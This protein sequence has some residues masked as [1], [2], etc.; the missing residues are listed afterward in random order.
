MSERTKA[1]VRAVA[2]DPDR[3]NRLLML[4]DVLIE[5]ARR[6]GPPNEQSAQ[7]VQTAIA[8]EVL[9]FVPVRLENLRSLRMG[10]HLLEGADKRLR[11][12]LAGSETKTGEPYHAILPEEVTRHLKVYQD[13]Y[14]PLLTPGP[15]DWL[16]PGMFVDRPKTGDALRT[17]LRKAIAIR[18]GVI[19]T[20][21]CFRALA[22]WMV[23]KND[24]HAHGVVQR[25]LGHKQLSTT[26]AYYTGLEQSQ[27][28][29]SYDALLLR[30]RQ[31]AAKSATPLRR[32]KG[33]PK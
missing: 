11:V 25:I 1:R 27:A 28:V 7:Q 5:E 3:L 10:V 2:E 14:R 4:P 6:A 22:G 24:P 12:S 8:L 9:L 31:K 33:N 32:A 19:L 16:F 20:P 30:E 23:L 13:R 15:C 29:E 26:M 21:H 18:C 17:Q